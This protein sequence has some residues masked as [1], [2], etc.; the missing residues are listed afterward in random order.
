MNTAKGF[1]EVLVPQKSGIKKNALR[2]FIL[3]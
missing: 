3:K 2:Q 1:K